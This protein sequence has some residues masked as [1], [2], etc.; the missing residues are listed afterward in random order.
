MRKIL[1]AMPIYTGAFSHETF[2][3]IS[4]ASGECAERGWNLTFNP[5]I[6]DALI[7]RARNVMFSEFYHGP[8]DDMVFLDH[9]IAPALGMFTRLLEHPVDLVGAAYPKRMD[10]DR[11]TFHPLDDR[12]CFEPSGL[13]EV[14]GIGCG[15]MRIT[16][17]AADK[18][19]EAH[20]DRWFTDSSAPH[21][22]K[23]FHVFECELRGHM[24]FSEDY[25]FCRKYRELGGK[26]WIDPE[27]EISHRGVKSYTGRFGDWLRDKGA[28]AGIGRGTIAEDARRLLERHAA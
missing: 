1:L 16:R 26:V 4:E 13:I 21:L 11:Y 25:T 27:I 3:A 7:T 24:Y 6:G 20:R 8:Y 10:I 5:R 12:L 15:M 28:K 17:A 23:I 19:V 18:I 9:D 2:K 14:A 22:D